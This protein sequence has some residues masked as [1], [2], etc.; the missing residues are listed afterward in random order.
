MRGPSRALGAA[1]A[2]LALGFTAACGDSGGVGGADAAKQDKATAG[3]TVTLNYWTWFPPEATLKEAIS[4]FEKANPNI[5][6]I[7]RV[8]ES[9]D[10]QKQLPLAMN[11]GQSLDLVGVQISAMTNTVREQLRPVADWQDELPAGCRYVETGDTDSTKTLVAC[12]LTASDV[13]SSQQDP[14]QKCREKYGDNVVVHV[15]VPAGAIVCTPPADG[16]YSATCSSM[17]WVVGEST[18]E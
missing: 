16:Q 12:D 14:K 3:E 15:P 6:I 8:F 7:L 1:A 18:H 13:L 11:G 4:A 17:P 9:A 10:Y 2:V 5:K